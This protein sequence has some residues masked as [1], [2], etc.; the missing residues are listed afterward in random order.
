MPQPKRER[1]RARSMGHEMIADT[2]TASVIQCDLQEEIENLHK[3]SAWLQETG[4][5]SKTLVR[6]P[7][8]R[9]VLIAMRTKMRMHQHSTGARISVQTLAGYI[10]LRLPEHTVEMLLGSCSCSIS[11]CRMMWKRRMTARFCCLSRG[12][13]TE[14]TNLKPTGGSSLD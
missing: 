1:S 11:A 14:P 8:L 9:I 12:L 6:H 4:A 13:P 5:S 7:D 10:R 3:D 2:L